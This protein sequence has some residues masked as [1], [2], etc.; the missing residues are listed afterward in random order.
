MIS[1]W[2]TFLLRLAHSNRANTIGPVEPAL[3]SRRLR[4]VNSPEWA[5][6][7]TT[8]RC[9]RSPI[10]E[11]WS[12]KRKPSLRDRREFIRGVTVASI[13]SA[14][15]LHTAQAAAQPRSGGTIV[16]AREGQLI[17]KTPDGRQ[18]TVKVDSELRSR[19]GPSCTCR[20]G[21]GMGSATT[22]RIRSA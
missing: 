17:P 14:V 1:L 2:S 11:S 3:E 12:V 5:Q 4:I 9:A 18:V 16:H 8:P 10:E 21:C 7:G 13:G 6:V 19:P 15:A 20:K 22:E